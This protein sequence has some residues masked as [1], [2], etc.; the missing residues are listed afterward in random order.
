MLSSQL[1]SIS[2]MLSAGVPDLQGKVDLTNKWTTASC[3][4]GFNP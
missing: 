4:C 1:E 2:V 3:S